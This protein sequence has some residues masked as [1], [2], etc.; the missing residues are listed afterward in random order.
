MDSDSFFVMRGH[1]LAVEAWLGEQEDTARMSTLLGNM[2]PVPGMAIRAGYDPVAVIA[3]NGEYIQWSHYC[4]GVLLF[5]RTKLSF[6]ILDY[7][8][9]TTVKWD[10]SSLFDRPWEQ[11][12]LNDFVMH[13]FAQSF[14]VAPGEVVQSKDGDIIRHLWSPYGDEV[15]TN[16]SRHYLADLLE[17]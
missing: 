11:K 8:F 12:P 17:R 1:E 5:T 7:W 10:T 16:L 9:N 14:W 13:R 2:Y 3:D 4:T 6:E 15:R